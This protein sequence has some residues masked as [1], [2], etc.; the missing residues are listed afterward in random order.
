MSMQDEVAVG[1][2]EEHAVVDT[3]ASKGDHEAHGEPEEVEDD[4]AE[5]DNHD[6]EQ[7]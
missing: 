5:G 4:D 7:D 1:E 2:A 3:E 6:D